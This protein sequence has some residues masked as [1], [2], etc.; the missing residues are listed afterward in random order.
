M[1]T[2][3]TAALTL[4][5]GLLAAAPA[6]RA[7]GWLAKPG[8]TGVE[9]AEVG[10]AKLT[11]PPGKWELVG[12]LGQ[13]S[14]GS[15]AVAWKR[16]IYLQESDGLVGTFLV[17]GANDG[18]AS[19]RSRRSVPQLCSLKTGK[20]M[21]A[22]AKTIDYGTGAHD[23]LLASFIPP[24]DPTDS[25]LWRKISKRAQPI[26]DLPPAFVYIAFNMTSQSRSDAVMVE[27]FINPATPSFRS[28]IWGSA[29]PEQSRAVDDILA[30]TAA[31]AKAFRPT[32]AAAL[33]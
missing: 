25:P 7:Q 24:G 16:R 9:T 4:L 27:L 30:V 13:G 21:V 22:D 29:T 10:D 17:I 18:A 23:C 12:D 11:L 26:G 31:W 32:V 19:V 6:A 33:P 1:R 2:L 3:I 14:T 15:N 20:G 8:L 28:A 5:A